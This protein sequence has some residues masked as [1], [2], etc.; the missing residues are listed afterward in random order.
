[1]EKIV[2]EEKGPE[3][4]ADPTACQEGFGDSDESRFTEVKVVGIA[5][6]WAEK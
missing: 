5:P 3:R 1:M 6:R 2:L 4:N